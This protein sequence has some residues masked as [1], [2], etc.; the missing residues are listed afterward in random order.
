MRKKQWEKSNSNKEKSNSSIR[1]K[2]IATG[3]E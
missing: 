2:V 3:E 1:N